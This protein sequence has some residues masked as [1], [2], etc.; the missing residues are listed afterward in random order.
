MIFLS[1]CG[2]DAAAGTFYSGKFSFEEFEEYTKK[3]VM[4]SERKTV[5]HFKKDLIDDEDMITGEIKGGGVEFTDGISD[6]WGGIRFPGGETGQNLIGFP[7]KLFSI[8]VIR[9]LCGSSRRTLW[10][11]PVLFICGI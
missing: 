11:G 9:L 3:Q 10:N 7:G 8:T 2:C 6:I 1:S 5:F 4:H